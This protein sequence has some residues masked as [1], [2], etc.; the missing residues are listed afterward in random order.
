MFVISNLLSILRFVQTGQISQLQ[1]VIE[2]LRKLMNSLLI[3]MMS[4]SAPV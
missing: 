2:Y 1:F 3:Y 4:R